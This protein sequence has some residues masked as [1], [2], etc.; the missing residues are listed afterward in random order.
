[1][2]PKLLA[3]LAN[4]TSV[5]RTRRKLREFK[6]REKQNW[7]KVRVYSPLFSLDTRVISTN[8]LKSA[9]NALERLFSLFEISNNFV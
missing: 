9:L 2:E 7:E 8:L 1:M 5:K 3:I 4:E 6:S